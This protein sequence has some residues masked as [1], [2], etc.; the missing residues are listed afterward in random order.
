MSRLPSTADARPYKKLWSIKCYWEFIQS[1]SE[2]IPKIKE[3]YHSDCLHAHNLH[4]VYIIMQIVARYIHVVHL[5]IFVCFQKVAVSM[6]V[7]PDKATNKLKEQHCVDGEPYMEKDEFP[8][9]SSPSIED[10]FREATLVAT[11]AESFSSNTFQRVP[12]RCHNS[13]TRGTW[14]SRASTYWKW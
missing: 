12:E 9:P 6:D 5:Q 7:D 4:E 14:L 1:I 2:T 8:F 13:N 3:P 11:L 10:T